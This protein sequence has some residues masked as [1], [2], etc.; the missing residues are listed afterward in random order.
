M[1]GEKMD[2]VLVGE[3]LAINKIMGGLWG[4]AGSTVQPLRTERMKI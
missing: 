4:A 3:A 2:G 1:E